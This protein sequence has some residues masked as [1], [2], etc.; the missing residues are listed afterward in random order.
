MG[1]KNEDT[2]WDFGLDKNCDELNSLGLLPRFT[3]VPD[4]IWIEC[5]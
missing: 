5:L 4:R 3:H 1:W 2:K